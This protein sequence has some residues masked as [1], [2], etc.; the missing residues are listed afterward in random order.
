[1]DQK[2]W[3]YIFPLYK[4]AVTFLKLNIFWF[5][6]FLTISTYSET[7]KNEI[8]LPKT[9]LWGSPTPS[10]LLKTLKSGIFDPIT[11]VYIFKKYCYMKVVIEIMS[12]GGV[13]GFKPTPF[14]EYW[15][16]GPKTPGTYSL[17]TIFYES[18]DIFEKSWF[19]RSGGRLEV[20][21]YLK[22]H[23]FQRIFPYRFIKEKPSSPTLR[24]PPDRKNW[25][26]S[27]FFYSS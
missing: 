3:F 18:F 25:D 20:K 1:M 7:F 19:S 27:D 10:K 6:F 13:Q 22:N 24:G 12:W 8:D 4:M 14:E 17:W 2:S 11:S 9:H 26:F 15:V 21:N 16:S 23:W 5:G